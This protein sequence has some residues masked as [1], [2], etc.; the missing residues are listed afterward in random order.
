MYAHTHTHT[1]W[2]YEFNAWNVY[3]VASFRLRFSRH[4]IQ[5]L[6]RHHAFNIAKIMMLI[7]CLR[8]YVL[9]LSF[10]GPFLSLPLRLPAS[11][12][13][14]ENEFHVNVKW[15]LQKGI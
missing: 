4:Q 2:K 10:T 9:P 12:L 13:A 1:G 6:L 15:V 5:M 7:L 3:L 14:L 11:D 8:Q